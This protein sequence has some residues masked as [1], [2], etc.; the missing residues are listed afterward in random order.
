VLVVADGDHVV[1][2]DNRCPHM[3]FPLHRG[4]HRGRCPHLPLASCPFRSAQ[5]FDL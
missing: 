4:E 5:R 3:G 1:A 2:L